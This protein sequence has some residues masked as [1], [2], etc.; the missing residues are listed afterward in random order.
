MHAID[1]C[2]PRRSS[3]ELSAPIVYVVDGDHSA[4]K[5]LEYLIRSAGW[6]ARA[7]ASGEEFLARPR[8]M[9]PGCLLVEQSLPGLCGLEVQRLVLDRSEMP[10]IFM[11]GR[12]DLRITVQAMKAGA[13]EFLVKPL[14][15]ATVLKAIADAIAQSRTALPNATQGVELRAR[16]ESL[17]PR[18][19]AVMDL[20][21]RGHLNK[22]VGSALGISE[23]TVKAHRGKAMRK[24]QATSIAEL[25]NMAARIRR[26]MAPRAITSTG[27][28]FM[29]GPLSPEAFDRLACA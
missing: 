28:A 11:S 14:E 24:M 21:V 29:P 18:E 9:A 12:P 23:I 3:N 13:F 4:R 15:H 17:S 20:V 7:A 16:Y 27:G 5:E 6:Q 26:G 25:V 1:T 22:Q 19:R 10:I 8:I 2:P